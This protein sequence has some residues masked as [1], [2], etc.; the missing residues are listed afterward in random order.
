M[1][2]CWKNWSIAPHILNLGN[3]RRWVVSFMPRP[4]YPQGK[5]RAPPPRTHW[6]GDWVGLRA[7]LDTAVVKRK[8]PCPYRES[9]PSRP[10]RSLVTILT[11]VPRLHMHVV[12]NLIHRNSNCAVLINVYTH[13]VISNIFNGRAA[14][15]SEDNNL[16][17]THILEVQP[18][19]PS[20]FV[21][22]S[23]LS[24]GLPGSLFPSGFLT[25]ILY[26]YHLCDKWFLLLLLLLLLLAS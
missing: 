24:L 4:F 17:R 1:K 25:E 11:E 7:G 5:E 22:S 19:L 8:N 9:N 21:L 2:T 6:L 12:K 15:T 18:L 10:G 20:V 23:H 16:L 3:R 26:A 14:L 13:L